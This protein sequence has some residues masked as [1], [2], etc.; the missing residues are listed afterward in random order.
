M[1]INVGKENTK[2]YK[3]TI[4]E[5]VLKIQKMKETKVCPQNL[6]TRI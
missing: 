5:N 6:F 2:I 1:T 3:F 4:N